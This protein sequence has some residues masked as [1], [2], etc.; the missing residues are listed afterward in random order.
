MSAIYFHT[1][2]GPSA[3]LERISEMC[4][5]WLAGNAG[6]K[7]SPKMRHLGTIVQLCRTISSQL[8]HVWTIEKILLNGNTSSAGPDNIVNFSLYQ[9]L[10]SVGEFEAP[11]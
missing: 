4:C 9:R 5:T 1:W 3:N 11:L 6:P 10:R 7:K 8:R 2:C